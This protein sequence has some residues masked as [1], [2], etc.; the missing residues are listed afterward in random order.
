M[1]DAADLTGAAKVALLGETVARNLFGEADP[2][3]QTIRIRKVPFTVIGMLE[4]KGQ[5]MWGRTRTT[6]S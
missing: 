3:G 4:R 5:N 2:I 1:F 6:S